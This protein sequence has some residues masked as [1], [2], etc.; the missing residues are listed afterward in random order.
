VLK[1]GAPGNVLTG[2]DGNDLD[3]AILPEH[4][5][6]SGSTTVRVFPGFLVGVQGM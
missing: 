1:G 4:V 6:C 2:W 5:A 3:L